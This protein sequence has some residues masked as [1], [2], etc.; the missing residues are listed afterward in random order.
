MAPV[1]DNV[2]VNGRSR[3]TVRINSALDSGSIQ[4]RNDYEAVGG[5]KHVLL[6]FLQSRLVPTLFEKVVV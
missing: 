3:P 5:V 1:L 6:F 2:V 4:G